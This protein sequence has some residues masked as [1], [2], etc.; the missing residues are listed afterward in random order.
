MQLASVIED[1][2]DSRVR[3]AVILTSIDGTDVDLPALVDRARRYGLRIVGPGS[4]GVATSERSIGLQASLVP[5]ELPP[6]PVAI[7]L[8]SGSLGASVLRLAASSASACRGSCRSATRR[9]VSGNDLLQF[10]EDDE[11][12]QVIAMYTETFGNPR[13]FARIARR[14]SRRRP[15]VAVRTGAA[16]IGPTGG[17]LYQQAGLIEVP[18][19]AA[20][21]DTARVLAT[22]PMLNGPRVAV[23]TNARSPAVLARE[24]LSTA[25]PRA[26]RAADLRSTGDRP[27]TTTASPP[28]P[29]SPTTGI[30]AVA[31]RP[32][33][34]ARRGHRRPDR[35]AS[36][37]RSPVPPS[38]WSSC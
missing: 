25:G 31:D 13:K 34:A 16:A 33:P 8:Q 14:V 15:I 23:L 11:A 29:R 26:G 5:V 12:T 32:R 1:C 9:D 10:W 4:M 18:T 22:A 38:R 6:G 7:S 28:A 21:L 30:D 24:A 35:S 17:A 2:I 20:L 19:V 3:G 37:R 36:T 27:R